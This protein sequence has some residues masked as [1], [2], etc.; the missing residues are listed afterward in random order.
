MS[1]SGRIYISTSVKFNE[2]SF[3]FENDSSFRKQELVKEG[4]KVA[5]LEKSQVVS[6]SVNGPH[7]LTQVTTTHGNSPNTTGNTEC[8]PS[9]IQN[10]MQQV[11]DTDTIPG[12]PSTHSPPQIIETNTQNLHTQKT[13]SSHS[14]VTRS[15]ASIFKPK[16]YQVF[17]KT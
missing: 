5:L 13:L 6:F 7:S 9:P 14:M 3:P 16:L 15:K 10:E 8:S 11:N 2:N 1:N 17:S 4:N 12:S